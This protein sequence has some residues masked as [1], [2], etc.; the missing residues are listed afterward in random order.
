VLEAAQVPA[1]MSALTAFRPGF[2]VVG[3]QLRA[4]STLM[5]PTITS[6][7]LEVAFAIGLWLLLGP[8]SPGRGARLWMLGAL[9]LIGAGIAATFTR[10]GLIGMVAAIGLTA[11]IVHARLGLTR[12]QAGLLVALVVGVIVAT[13]VLHSPER[14][15]ARLSTDGSQAWYGVRYQVPPQL[16]LATGRA[17]QVPVS[18]ANTGRLTWDSAREPRFTLSY[19][20]LRG[21]SDLVV[22]FEGQR[23][24]FP[25]PVAPGQAVSLTAD[26]I[27]PALAGDYTLVWDVVH[28]TRAWLSSEGVT[29]ARTAVRVHGAPVAAVPTTRTR[30]PEVAMRPDRRALWRAA[31]AMAADRPIAGVGPDNFRHQYGAYLDPD[32][33]DPRVHA[34]NMYLETLTGAGV[35][36]LLALVWLLAASGRALVSRCRTAPPSHVAAAAAMFSAWLMVAG[37]GLV[38]SFLTFTTT[39]LTFAM[40]AGLAF[41]RAWSP[42]LCTCA[43]HPC[44]SAPVHRTAP[45]APDHAH[46]L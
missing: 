9:T 32:R 29:P 38:D 40:A 28:E 16:T 45:I 27:A 37:H 13:L 4:T 20:W 6:M 3:G 44:T 21:D 26:V 14:L 12:R 46:C 22:H 1:V 41:S 33:A 39:Y 18:L 5:Y 30:L 10:A 43:P 11:A 24:A 19:H 17:Y 35:P 8:T 36:G 31:L 34:N 42:H 15:A 25:S 7:Y 23:T 2:H